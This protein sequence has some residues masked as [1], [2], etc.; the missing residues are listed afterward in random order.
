MAYPQSHTMKYKQ[1]TPHLDL[2]LRNTHM[3]RPYGE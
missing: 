1:S 2:E 3:V